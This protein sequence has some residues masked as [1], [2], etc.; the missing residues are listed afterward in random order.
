M[1][2]RMASPF[3]RVAHW[4]GRIAE[5]ADALQEWP[6]M[7]T[8]ATLRQRFRED[9]LSLTASSLTFTTVL[10]LVPLLAV[11]FTVFAAAPMLADLRLDFET[12]VLPSLLPGEIAR[13]VLAG[14]T[15][16]AERALALGGIGLATLLFTVLLLMLTVDQTLNAIWRVR[17][18]RPLGQRILVY[19]AAVTLGPIV[20]AVSLAV[21][22][23][24]LSDAPGADGA[25]RTGTAWLLR[26]VDFALL[27]ALAAGLF[28]YVPNTQVR[29]R[30]AW[31]GGLFVAV[32]FG[33]AKRAMA[34]Y[35]E[36]FPGTAAIYGAA[37]ALPVLLL[38]IYAVWVVVLLGAV[39]AA[40][41]P[42]LSMQVRRPPA[43]PGCRF[44][45][46]LELLAEFARARSGP[47]RG[48][49]LHELAAALRLDPLAVEPVLDTLIALDWVGRLDEAGTPRCVLTCDP[50]TT[51][52]APLVDALLLS[53]TTAS[54]R[55]RER[56]GLS[57]LRV[58]D[59]ID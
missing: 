1:I 58:A 10:A 15:A 11:V 16:F 34:W 20:L 36:S 54:A 7:A 51:P 52:A 46:A 26:G 17:R 27:A 56:A 49:S 2:G 22:S 29:W 40:Y 47:R 5:L 9:H 59:L 24:V 3:A 25:A 32:G 38:W 43:T 44:D 55:F 4:R 6:W 53:P 30:H 33:V 37:A 14:L 48:R 12:R 57:R 18:P 39:I 8:L 50:A 19:W 28:H 23:Y 21:S 31:M 41:A 42:S 13:P 35:V 45:L